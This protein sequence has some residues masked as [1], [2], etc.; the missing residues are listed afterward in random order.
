MTNFL[1]RLAE[2]VLNRPLLVTADRAAV[3]LDVLAGR[4]GIDP[5][6]AGQKP[7]ARPAQSEAD[8]LPEQTPPRRGY[9]VR[10]RSAVIAVTG[11]LVNRGSWIDADSGLMSYDAI[12]RALAAA[13]D[14]PEIEQI[15]LDVD[16]PGGE[17]GGVA[18]LAGTIRAVNAQ[19]PVTAVVNDT[20]ASAAYWLASAAGRIVISPTSALGSV[21]VVW[22]HVD[23]AR[24]LEKEGR[25]VTLIHAGAFK[26]DGNPYGP[27]PEEAR[28]R[29]QGEIDALYDVFVAAVA[30]NRGLDEADV[31]A[32][33]AGIFIGRA[34][35]DAGFADAIGSLDEVI[36]DV[37]AP[38]PGGALQGPGL[39]G[40]KG[41]MMS[42]PQESNK[43]PVPAAS[44]AAPET[45]KTDKTAIPQTLDQTLAQARARAAEEARAR[46]AAILEAKEARGRD[47]LARELAF[48]T[49]LSAEA[50]VRI[51]AAAAKD[52]PGKSASLD[53]AQA[54]ARTGLD[55]AVEADDAPAAAAAPAKI[56]IGG[57]Y[58]ARRK[59]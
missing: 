27:L 58:A 30:R 59:N 49:D 1:P 47:H 34:A 57:V 20:A 12:A 3:L 36:G 52:A 48:G 17:A 6:A 25:R 46:I 31:R 37:A 21:G 39:A 8:V 44:K 35:I 19:K 15:I 16:S 54:I 22:A 51:L 53:L 24:A 26:T 4:I 50:A 43:A 7:A 29:I 14:D 5:G 40:R 13:L 41:E 11:S 18:Q 10:A 45:A 9:E 32:T 42:K 23:N 2:R 55:N 28:A 33:E 38:A 56:D